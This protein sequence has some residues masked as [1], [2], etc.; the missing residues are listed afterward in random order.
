MFAM[1]AALAVKVP[2]RSG[3]SSGQRIDLARPPAREERLGVSPLDPRTHLRAEHQAL[4]LLPR[5]FSAEAAVVAAVE[6][7]RDRSE[8]G[9]RIKDLR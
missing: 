8:L 5:M 3:T 2:N 1:S 7:M 4:E 6:N 9:D